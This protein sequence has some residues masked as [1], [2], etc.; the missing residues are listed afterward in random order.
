MLDFTPEQ[1]AQMNDDFSR[2]RPDIRDIA[3][4]MFKRGD[5]WRD[6]EYRTLLFSSQMKACFYHSHI[7][8]L[9]EQAALASRYWAGAVMPPPEQAR[10]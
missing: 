8:T 10:L 9:N 1:I 2:I 4:R 6:I 3:V 5:R 7:E